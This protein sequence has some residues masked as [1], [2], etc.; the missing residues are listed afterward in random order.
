MKIYTKSGDKGLTSLASGKRVSK[1][2]KL[3]ELYGT[4]DE[5]NSFIGVAISFLDNNSKLI[6]PLTKIQNL[7]F[8][9]GSELAGYKADLDKSAITNQDIQFLET[10]IDKIEESLEPLREFILPAGTKTASLLHVCRT[11]SRRLER[12][13]IVNTEQGISVDSNILIFLNRLSDY[14]FV[15]ARF[16]N[17]SNQILDT[18]WKSR[19]QS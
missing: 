15:A 7:L 17:H 12:L 4:T 19:N 9:I 11:V 14:F 18:K 16:E 10:E 1:S 6:E 13:A 2:D 5:L 3:V 8:E